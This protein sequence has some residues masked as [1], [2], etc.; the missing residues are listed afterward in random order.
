MH[1]IVMG[2]PKENLSPPLPLPYPK[3]YPI[4]VPGII[5][6]ANTSHFIIIF[7]DAFH[8]Y[9]YPFFN[10]NRLNIETIFIL[11]NSLQII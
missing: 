9:K 5:R 11:Q 8:A 4:I 10:L 3:I 2:I 1:N 6:C 7:V